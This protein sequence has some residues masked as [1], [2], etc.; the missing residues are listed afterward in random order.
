[1]KRL[2]LAGAG[3]SQLA[4]LRA[5]ALRRSADLEVVLL[6]PHDR[7]IYSGMLPGW[8]A[9]HYAVDEIDIPLAP[10]ARAAG[11]RLV[12][13][14]LDSID[15]E[16]RTVRTRTGTSLEFDVAA[17]A[18]G[19]VMDLHGIAGAEQHAL[20]LRP[21]E[22]FIERWALLQLRLAAMPQPI[23]TVIG[24]GAAGI[25][26]ALAI[27]HRMRSTR[28]DARIQLISG[29]PL[30]DRHAAAARGPVERTLRLRGIRVLEEVVG[31]VDAGSVHLLDG[32]ALNTDATIIA[33][34]VAPPAWIEPSGLASDER[35]F[36]AVDS[37][38]RSS[39]HPAVFAAGDIATM[40][41]SPRPKSGV[42]AVRAGPV[43]AY[44][45]I[46]AAH[47]RPLRRHRPQPLA[48]YLLSTGKPH[49]IASWGP[50][51]IQGDSLWRWKDRI[52]RGFISKFR[53]T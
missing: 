2:L 52:D 32:P 33:T 51:A 49:A 23:V 10:L 43:L 38:L 3:H 19:A 11:A 18:T 35:G 25:E 21:F 4:V 46:A 6:T 36:I 34:G 12:L 50:L 45:V 37:R 47:G 14:E 31:H 27:S 53:L 15:P 22:Q 29:G 28:A 13:D 7:Q 9:G 48:L 20:P 40:I 39:S 42:Y 30:L 24:G 17:I 16:Q 41:G 44:N 8:V 5:L 1:M 26:V